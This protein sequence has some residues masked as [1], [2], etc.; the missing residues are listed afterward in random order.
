MLNFL[1]ENF[2]LPLADFFQKTA[3]IKELK[4]WRNKI[5]WM[6]ENELNQLQKE[7]LSKVLNQSIKNIPFYKNLNLR[8]SHNPYDD[9][10]KFPVMTKDLMKENMEHL[11]IYDPKKMIVEKSSG[12]SG[13]QGK[14]YM[15]LAEARKAQAI[16][17]SIWEWCGYKIGEPLI[18]TGITPN[19]GLLK[20][21]KDKL[22]NTLYVDAYNLNEENV[23]AVLNKTKRERYKYFGGYASSINV[24]ALIA[25]KNNI[26]LNFNGVISWGD[27]LFDHYR[28][29]ILE[30]FGNPVITELYG[31]TEG[32]IISATCKFG[33]HHLITPQT[34]LEVLDKD[35]NEVADG[36]LGYV[37]VTRLDALQFPLIRY[38]LGDL[39]I[40]EN[41]A[42]K[43]ECGLHLPL[44]QKVIGRDTDVVYTPSGKTLIV[45]FFTG[46]FEH[47][48]EVKQFRVVQR[49][50]NKIE[51]EY[52][53]SELFTDETLEKIRQT[54]FSRANEVFEITFIKVNGIPATASGKPQIIQNFI[55]AKLDS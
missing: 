2:I 16:Q 36:E 14:V 9:I 20:S 38:Y 48:E 3:F 28:K 17:T 7:A 6:N 55:A 24:Y 32:F 47:F 26:K 53:P 41:A 18:Q 5:L 22:F 52:I 40:K 30:A 46:I 51:I 21:I 34:Y 13:I 43:C 4:L 45:H 42:K 54:I 33:H 11:L 15:S 10:K 35:G 1:T 23:V 12:S 50:A 29:N 37:V 31:S 44:L 49:N 25:K 8:L 27:K 19:R 39:A